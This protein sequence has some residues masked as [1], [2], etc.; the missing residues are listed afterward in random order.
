MSAFVDPATGRTI[1]RLTNS[2]MDDKHTYYDISPWSAD[3]RMLLF[4]SAYPDDLTITHGDSVATNRGYLYLMDTETFEVRQIAGDGFFTAH[5]GTGAMWH[6]SGQKIYYYTAPGQVAAVNV[7]NGHREHVMSGGIRQLSPDGAKFAWTINEA[8]PEHPQT[9]VY[10]MNEDGSDVRL[11]VPTE[12]LYEL[13]PN[14][15]RFALA[16]MTVGNTKW[17]PDGQHMLVAMWVKSTPGDLTPWNSRPRRSIYIVSRDGSERRWLTFFGHHHSWT[18]NGT[19]VLYS[20]YMEHSDDGVRQTP[21]LYL[22]DFDGSNKRIVIDQPLGGHPVAS[23]DGALITTW[24]DQGVILVDVAKQRV[25]YLAMLQPGFDMTHRGTHPHCIWHPEGGL[26][27]YN[28][29]QT[30]HSQLYQIAL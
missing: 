30:G 16:Q 1:Q 20:G 27:L 2:Q 17:T 13:T 29:A 28:S 21:R 6:P 19:Q 9:G 5:T 11:I 3:A 4:S 24:D 23:P 15:D 22:I 12:A 26:V 14:R 8:T 18:A 7:E 25:E 10:T